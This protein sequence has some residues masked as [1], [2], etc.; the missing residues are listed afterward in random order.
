MYEFAFGAFLNTIP[1]TAVQELNCDAI[2]SQYPN[3]SSAFP[4]RFAEK[5]RISILP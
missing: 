2:E 4:Y 5:A 3:V 1:V